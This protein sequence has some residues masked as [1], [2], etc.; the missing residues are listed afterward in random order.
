MEIP[1]TLDV[2][3]GLSRYLISGVMPFRARPPASG[4][5]GG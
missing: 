4:G 3:T 5:D 1:F 2:M